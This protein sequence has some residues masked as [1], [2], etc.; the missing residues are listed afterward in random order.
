MNLLIK[1]DLKN[2]KLML[3]PVIVIFICESLDIFD[4][5]VAF[6]IYLAM[7][8]YL[9]FSLQKIVI[10]KI[11][12]MWIYIFTIVYATII[13]MILHGSRSVAR[14]LYY[15]LPTL[16]LIIL[17]YYLY[18][19]YG[20]KTSLVKTLIVCGTFMSTCVWIK[21]L[22]NH[23]ISDEYDRMKMILGEHST[24]VLFIFGT[25]FFYMFIKQ[26]RLF[27]RFFRWYSFLIMLSQLALCMQRN[28]WAS[29]LVG[30]VCT[31]V[32]TI[33]K[34]YRRRMVRL[35]ITI[36]IS[37]TIVVSVFFIIAPEKVTETIM[38]KNSRTIEEI[39]SDI[40]YKNVDDA[41]ANWRGYE[42]Q[43]AEKQWKNSGILAEIFGTGMGTG[44]HLELVPYTWEDITT[45]GEIPLLH[46]GYYTMLNKTGVVGV[47]ALIWFMFANVVIGYKLL[48]NRDDM[49]IEAGILI[50]ISVVYLVQTY[51]ARGPV[52]QDA[53]IVWPLIVGWVSAKSCRGQ[54]LNKVDNEGEK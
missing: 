25:M 17:G 54:V 11:K 32:M 9:I 41:I 39:N 47:I 35:G 30:F 16:T 7:V 3:W 2:L 10:P 34:E 38:D 31:A 53:N 45:T 33:K 36:A 15:V 19:F 14:D 50:S 18:M 26:E 1:I 40:E 6:L 20:S 48:K 24:E 42:I 51:V 52:I 13:G 5:K 46:N 28:I 4:T 29:L 22:M 8:A 27:N 23:S 44:I 12:G 43:S 37:A 49:D 21:F